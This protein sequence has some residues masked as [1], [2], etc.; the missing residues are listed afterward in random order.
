MPRKREKSTTTPRSI[1]I[2]LVMVII[3]CYWIMM[4]FFFGSGESGTITLMYNVVFSVLVLNLAN[5]F[6]FRHFP[7]FSLKQSELLT[8]YVMLTIASVLASHFTIQVLVPIIPHAYQFATTENEWQNLFWRYI[9]NWLTI[10]N[11]KVFTD[12]Y[13]GESTLYTMTNIQGWLEPILWWT[14][15]LSAL[16]LATLGLN[17][18][19]RKQW[20]EQEK[21]SYPLIQLPLEMTSTETR[22]FRNR[23]MWTCFIFSFGINVLNGLH[24]NMA[25][26]TQCNQR[27][28]I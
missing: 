1:L 11:P 6:L 25:S 8:V 28:T 27:S 4:S 12:F 3:N 20:T 10:D 2:G 19:F 9:P 26:R 21:L 17:I 5:S 22:L 15:F 16:L 24:F 7:K 14:T 23:L 13:R 18:I